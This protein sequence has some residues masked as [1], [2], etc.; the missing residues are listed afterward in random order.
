VA[1]ASA[2]ILA[3]VAGGAGIAW[4]SIPDTAGV[5]HGCYPTNPS[6]KVLF[7][8][9]PATGRCPVGFTP[10]A[11]NQTGPV[12]P[13]GPQGSPGI[14][15][16]DGTNGKDGVNGRDG[17]N[18]KDGSPG[19]PG[20]SGTSAVYS[21]GGANN[22]LEVGIGTSGVTLQLPAGNYAVTAAAVVINGG[23]AQNANCSINGGHK[24]GATLG[25]FAD[26]TTIP[27]LARFTGPGAI[28]LACTGGPAGSS[29]SQIPRSRR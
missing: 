26:V 5:I 21:S 18:G 16:K 3:V 12:G 11:F 13:Q 9:D 17:T 2:A 7:L 4:A 23:D 24:F 20:P 22:G 19:A 10:I 25:A 8:V 1:A 6:L 27:V 15:G 29:C 28:T 14:N